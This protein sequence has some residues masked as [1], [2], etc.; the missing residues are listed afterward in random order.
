MKLP[1]FLVLV[2]TLVACAPSDEATEPESIPDLQRAESL[3]VFLPIGDATEGRAAFLEM[4][5]NVCHLVPGQNMDSPTAPRTELGPQL[6]A[7]LASQSRDEVAT[8]I[9]APSHVIDESIVEYTEG[10]VS[11]MGDYSNIMT[12]RQLMNIVAFLQPV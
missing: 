7:A 3:T 11:P 2:A 8:S 4:R 5:C 6:V 9:I 12:I 1:V 10:V